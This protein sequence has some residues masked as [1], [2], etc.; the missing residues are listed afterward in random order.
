MGA[1]DWSD[2]TSRDEP[3]RRWVKAV[4]CPACDALDV[5]RDSSK[6]AIAYWSCPCGHRWREP[7]EVGRDHVR[8]A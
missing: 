2:D 6:G 5:T 4:C 3:A 1:L 8:M 7:G